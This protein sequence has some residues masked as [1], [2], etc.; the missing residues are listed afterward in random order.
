MRYRGYGQTHTIVADALNHVFVPL[1]C[2]FLSVQ[3]SFMQRRIP[4]DN[5]AAERHEGHQTI[6]VCPEEGHQDGERSRGQDL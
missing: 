2:H 5:V 4:I 6:R 1:A 3:L